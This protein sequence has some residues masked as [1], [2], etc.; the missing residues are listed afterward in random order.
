MKE[1]E[2]MEFISY[3]LVD[4]ILFVFDYL[5]IA[6]SLLFFLIKK[7]IIII[8]LYLHKEKEGVESLSKNAIKLKEININFFSSELRILNN[9]KNIKDKNIKLSVNEIDEKEEDNGKLNDS[10]RNT[11]VNDMEKR[12]NNINNN[13]INN[14]V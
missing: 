7:I 9:N 10:K 8:Y 1:E 13:D 3:F 12:N 4:F 6:I 14:K 11:N 5:C 2:A